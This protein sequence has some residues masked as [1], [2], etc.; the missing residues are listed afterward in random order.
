M[1]AAWKQADDLRAFVGFV[2][3]RMDELEKRP[4]R[5]NLWLDWAHWRI[6]AL[7]PTRRNAQAVY[8]DFVRN[9]LHREREA[10]CGTEFDEDEFDEF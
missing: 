10:S 6:D 8:D 7:D 3:A 1:A 4:V 2:A 9:P 5:A